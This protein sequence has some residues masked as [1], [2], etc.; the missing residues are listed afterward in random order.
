MRDCVITRS[1]TLLNVDSRG[2]C[3]ACDRLG[4]DGDREKPCVDGQVMVRA[5]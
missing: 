2:T 5:S 3:V 1:G 4:E